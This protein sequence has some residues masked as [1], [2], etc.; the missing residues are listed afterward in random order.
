MK[1]THRLYEC[2]SLHKEIGRQV[3]NRFFGVSLCVVVSMLAST[4][5]AGTSSAQLIIGVTVSRSCAVD[6][7]PVAPTSSRVRLACTSG[8]ARS[9]HMNGVSRIG[10]MDRATDVVAPTAPYS[11]SQTQSDLR[12]LTV[13]F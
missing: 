12:V 5:A 11:P 8:A 9:L 13:N 6:T 10:G 3:A 2:L 1:R 7:Q 4:V